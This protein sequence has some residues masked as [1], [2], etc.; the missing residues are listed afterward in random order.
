VPVD[1]FV[2]KIVAEN[3]EVIKPVEIERLV[4]KMVEVQKLDYSLKLCPSI[5]YKLT[6]SLKFT[7]TDLL[8]FL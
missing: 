5:S 2:E 4:E 6:N 8:K 3:H 7:E 1:R